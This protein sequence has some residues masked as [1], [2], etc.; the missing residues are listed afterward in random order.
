MR[1][2][3]SIGKGK[4]IALRIAQDE[5]GVVHHIKKNIEQILLMSHNI[6]HLSKVKESKI[7]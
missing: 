6:K 2:N 3:H 5:D 4:K 1:S 7:L